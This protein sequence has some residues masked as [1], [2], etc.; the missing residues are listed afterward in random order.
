MQSIQDDRHLR[1]IILPE[2]GKQG[3]SLLHQS[4]V[5]VI[6]AGGLGGPALYYLT[7]AGVGTIHIV[8]EDVVSVTNLNRQILFTEAD[9]GKSKA[10]QACKRLG[11]LDSSVCLVPHAIRLNKSNIKSLFVGMDL[12]VD[13]VDNADTR[14]LVNKGCVDLGIPLIEAGINSMDGYIFPIIPHSTACFECA[15]PE[16]SAK[17]VGPIPVLGAAAGMIGSMQAGIAVRMLLKLPVPAWHQAPVQPFGPLEDHNS[18]Q[19]E[20]QMPR[21]AAPGRFD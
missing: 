12:I 8:D 20:S 5:C 13:C 9:L 11:A 16:A 21:L 6:G 1:Q 18:H 7:A 19:A 10:E 2:I 17:P 15:N 3:Q 4:R 14:H